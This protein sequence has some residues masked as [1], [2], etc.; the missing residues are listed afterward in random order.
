M[1]FDARG[2]PVLPQPSL[3]E[4][5]NVG[6][7]KVRAVLEELACECHGAQGDTTGTADLEEK[8]LVASL[9]RVSR[10]PGTRP[11]LLVEFLRDRAGLLEPAGWGC[12]RSRT[13]R[14]RS[15]WRPAR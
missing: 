8:E 14:S 5:L 13:A 4:F 6:R 15:T 7:E 9:L 12:T 1:R 11:G 10:N 3:S 2:E